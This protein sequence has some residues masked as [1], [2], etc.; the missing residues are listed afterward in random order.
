MWHWFQIWLDTCRLRDRYD[1]TRSGW[2]NFL[3][4]YFFAVEKIVPQLQNQLLDVLG[5]L[6]QRVAPDP[7]MIDLI[8]SKTNARSTLRGL[9]IEGFVYELYAATVLRC[10]KYN[11]PEFLQDLIHYYQDISAPITSRAF[12]PC[13]VPCRYHI[14]EAGHPRCPQAQGIF[15]QT[16]TGM[17][18]SNAP[19]GPMVTDG[20]ESR[21]NGTAR[22]HNTGLIPVLPDTGPESNAP[23]GPMV[24]EES[25]SRFNGTGQNNN[26]GTIPSVSNTGMPMSNAPRGPM[27]AE[28]S[29]SRFNGTRQDNNTGTSSS[30]PD[31]GPE[32]NVPRDHMAEEESES[33]FNGSEDFGYT[34]TTPSVPDTSPESNTPRRLMVEEEHFGYAGTSTSP[35]SNAPREPMVAEESENNFNGTGQFD[36]TKSIPSIPDWWNPGW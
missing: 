33:R 28:E 18:M 13:M 3:T 21:F 35:D 16:N 19:Y 14:H 31:T 12:R 2:I 20:F 24:A 15:A 8:W 22:N 34:G 1:L 32:S 5:D 30:V 11:N 36:D 29:E 7:R 10:H 26:T 25:E 27:V 6:I 9:V 23:H 17:P 4:L